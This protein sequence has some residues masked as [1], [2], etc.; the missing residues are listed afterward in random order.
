MSLDRIRLL[1]DQC[2]V[3]CLGTAD[4]QGRVHIPE[5]AQSAR[6]IHQS[7][8]DFIHRGEV[9][10]CGPGDKMLTLVCEECFVYTDRLP[11]QS[12]RLN[13][14]K[15]R[16]ERILG[17]CYECGGDLAQATFPEGQEDFARAEMPVK[18]G[19][20]VLYENRRDA[21]LRPTRFGPEFPEL[22]DDVYVVLLAEQHL[23]A[24]LE[25]AVAA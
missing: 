24:V 3:K 9:V 8:G 14:D 2:L 12:W 1:G 16:V 17:K 22:A 18:P 21:E 6:Q 11:T 4:K 10:K 20:I 15:S 5:S 7:G 23:L 19:D 25:P 13:L